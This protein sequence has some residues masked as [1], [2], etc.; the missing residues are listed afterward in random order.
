MENETILPPREPSSA[1]SHEEAINRSIFAC[2]SAATQDE[3]EQALKTL[4][5]A[6]CW[7]ED[8][9]ALVVRENTAIALVQTLVCT[10][11]NH[12]L[13]DDCILSCCKTL[14]TFNACVAT[15]RAATNKTNKNPMLKSQ[16]GALQT[17]LRLVKRIMCSA[18][19]SEADAEEWVKELF[20]D[21]GFQNP[22]ENQSV[23]ISTI[24][25]FVELVL[26]LPTKIAS[27][28][29]STRVD[30]PLW[31]I[32]SRYHMRLL[33]CSFQMVR[34]LRSSS[35]S[36]VAK[37]ARSYFKS[38][39]GRLVH[40]RRASDDVASA[41]YQCHQEK[42]TPTASPTF[43]SDK[44]FSDLILETIRQVPTYS[45]KA[46]LLRSILRHVVATGKDWN[47]G[48]TP[49]LLQVDRIC[50]DNFL[51]YLNITC[52]PILQESRQM[53]DAWVQLVVLSQSSAMSDDRMD[54]MFCHC[55]ALLLVSCR[56][57]I[58]GDMSDSDDDDSCNVDGNMEVIRKH[59]N[60]VAASWSQ[61]EFLRKSSQSLQNHVTNF[62]MSTMW[63]YSG[64]KEGDPDLA[65]SITRGVSIRLECSA[66]SS[67]KNGMLV[68]E[69]FARRLGDELR[70]DELQDTDRDVIMP[71][72]Q[73]GC[74]ENPSQNESELEVSKKER[75]QNPKQGRLRQRNFLNPDADYVSDDESEVLTQDDE[76]FTFSK[77][78]DDDAG[79]IWDDVD[80]LVPY[81]LEDDEEDLRVAPHPCYLS[82]CLQ[83]LRTPDT[84]DSAYCQQLTALQELPTLVRSRPT[85]LADY[86]HSLI[87]QLLRAENKFKI[88]GFEDMILTSLLSLA[89]EEPVLAGQCLI[90]EFFEEGSH[91]DRMNVLRTLQD[92]AYQLSAVKDLKGRIPDSISTRI[93]P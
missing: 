67:R 59:L 31:A 22:T 92:A 29:H 58:D 43:W 55:V 21:D 30:V 11:R 3:L 54:Q 4:R 81:D 35:D 56:G 73:S 36:V 18:S 12:R 2:Q 48:S 66:K 10:T 91:M 62:I 40:H 23:M 50:Q 37:T 90:T 70:F 47:N 19:S 39:V 15:L 41:L 84:D 68:G 65:D 75:D 45:E 89:V 63:L 82:E 49:T 5:N 77:G 34:R 24:N 33:E 71:P 26:L 86:T 79:S 42:A 6:P 93:I 52:V 69:L 14:A 72:S 7:D 13:L 76:E 17:T 88:E 74:F 27:A 87:M 20:L 46:L 38:L 16:F 80:E 57:S 9:T 85:D 44:D 28:C 53:R 64:K 78:D 1:T 8:Q 60:A 51:S 83:M 32:P 61:D 25:C